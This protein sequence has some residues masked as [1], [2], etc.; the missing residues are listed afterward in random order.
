MPLYLIS[1]D[2][3][4]DARR[5]KVATLLEGH[6]RRVQRSVFEC[7]LNETQYRRLR[8][9]LQQLLRPDE[10]DNV[11]IYR[12]CASCVSVI[13]IIGDGEVESTPDLYIF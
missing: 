3:G 5:L 10:G 4:P 6:G 9:R 2:I 11:R 1:Y 13:E 7:D 12:L 8:R